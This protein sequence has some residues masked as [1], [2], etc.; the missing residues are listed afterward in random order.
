MKILFVDDRLNEV[1]NLLEDSGCGS[2]HEIL[3]LEVFSSVERTCE[4]ARVH[5]P[6]AVFIGFGLSKWPITGADVVR[7]LR[8]QGFGG[9]IVGNSGG[10]PSSFE[11]E[12]IHIEH[13]SRKADLLK[14]FI[15]RHQS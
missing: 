10:G 1:K 2:T 4:L 9:Q 13:I 14:K 15:A 8:E 7:A 12:G 11:Q 3:P 6:D 5:Q